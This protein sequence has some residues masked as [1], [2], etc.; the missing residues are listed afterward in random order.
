VLWP[1]DVIA[2]DRPLVGSPEAAEVAALARR[3]DATVVPG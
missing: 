1:E 3:L 2:L